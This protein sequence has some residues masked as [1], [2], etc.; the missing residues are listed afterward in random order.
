V[1]VQCSLRVA[2][3]WP[4]LGRRATSARPLRVEFPLEG[5]A[6][7]AATAGLADQVVRRAGADDT[8]VDGGRRSLGRGGGYATRREA[9]G[10]RQYEAGRQPDHGLR[11]ASQELPAYPRPAVRADHDQV[12]MLVAGIA[13]DL[14][15]RAAGEK[16]GLPSVLAASVR[17]TAPPAGSVPAS[18]TWTMCRRALIS[19]A[20]SRA[21]LPAASDAREK[22]VAN[23]SSRIFMP[24]VTSKANATAQ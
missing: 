22:S 9:D 2:A 8:A 19:S 3:A 17:A 6:A 10:N 20:I 18:A 13:D 11:H 24:S 21:T 5:L 1:V 23:T 7:D 14:A 4:A 15:G 12:H 16:R